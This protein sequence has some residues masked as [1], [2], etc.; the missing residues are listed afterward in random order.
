MTTHFFLLVVSDKITHF[1]V[2]IMLL[3]IEKAEKSNDWKVDWL[4]SSYDILISAIDNF[5]NQWNPRTAPPWG[6]MLQNKFNRVIFYESK[7][8]SVRNFQ[9][10]LVNWKR[11]I[12]ENKY[13]KWRNLLAI[14]FGSRF[15]FVFCFF[16]FQFC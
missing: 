9:P 11:Y 2:K 4:K 16:V 14:F 6:I 3:I 7:L 10:T 12:N 1:V 13:R 15:C 5:F 8:V